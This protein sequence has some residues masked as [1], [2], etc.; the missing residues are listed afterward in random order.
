MRACAGAN[1][2]ATPSPAPRC[3]VAP[4]MSEVLQRPYSWFD[5]RKLPP[6]LHLIEIM[7]DFWD[8]GR[9]FVALPVVSALNHD[10]Q[11]AQPLR[12]ERTL[13]AGRTGGNLGRCR[14]GSWAART[15]RIRL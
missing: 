14:A 8:E 11:K 7:Y 2:A 15:R 5:D 9:R 10:P 13:G 3:V 12:R 4:G 6:A 1:P